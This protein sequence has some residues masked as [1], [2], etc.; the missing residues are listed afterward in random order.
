MQCDALDGLLEAVAVGELEPDAA[1]AAHLAGCGVCQRRLALARAI[2]ATL[3]A[4]PVPEPS[5]D[6]TS[7]VLARIRRDRWRA[8]QAIDIGFNVAVAAGLLLIIGG[9]AG[10]AWA[11]GLIAMG[12][13]LATLGGAAATALA[14]RLAPEMPVVTLAAALLTM[15]LGLWWW[16]ESDASA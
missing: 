8:E 16:A 11:G 6:F 2:D 12:R 4:R 10:L 14:A 13:D 3:A 5:P 15:T 7:G 1:A 9:V